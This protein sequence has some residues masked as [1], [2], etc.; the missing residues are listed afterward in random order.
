MRILTMNDS[1]GKLP[2]CIFIRLLTGF[3]TAFSVLLLY[4]VVLKAGFQRAPNINTIKQLALY[5]VVR[6]HASPSSRIFYNY[7]IHKYL[8]NNLHEMT[9][10]VH[11]G[12]FSRPGR[13]QSSNMNRLTVGYL[14]G[15]AAPNGGPLDA[16]DSAQAARFG[17]HTLSRGRVASS[18]ARL[19]SGNRH[20]L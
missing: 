4:F 17:T 1:T 11:F 12:G 14:A 15:W 18:C 19:I 20:H 9:T 6:P 13:A 2:L 8:F 16:M 5:I 10:N 7:F 3:I